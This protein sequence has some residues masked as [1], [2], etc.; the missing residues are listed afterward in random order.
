M[1]AEKSFIIQPEGKVVIKIVKNRKVIDGREE[2]NLVVNGAR[3]V[4][5]QL[6]AGINQA[7]NTV[8]KI[9]IGTG[10]TAP[11]LTNTA[12]EA[13]VARVPVINYRFPDLNTVEFEALVDQNTANNKTISELGLFTAGDATTPEVMI[14]RVVVSPINKDASTSLVILWRISLG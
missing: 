4:I 9:A 7:A 2:R 13:E 1:N 12:L 11:D 5:C 6:L 14:A 10:N 8:T 3:T